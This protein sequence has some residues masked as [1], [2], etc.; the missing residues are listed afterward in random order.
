DVRAGPDPDRVDVSPDDRV[1]PHARVV[2]ELDVPDD[3]GG[4][5][6]VDALPQARPDP[7][8]GP[9]HA[10]SSETL[11]LRQAKSRGQP[12]AGGRAASIR[13]GTDT[14]RP[15]LHRLVLAHRTARL[16]DGC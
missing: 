1:H 15:V 14:P 12:A 16:R 5:I 9:N 7:L 3:L 4:R 10:L 8:V 2:A 13:P 11:S 6:D